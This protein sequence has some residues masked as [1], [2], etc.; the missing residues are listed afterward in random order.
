MRMNV[1]QGKRGRPKKKR[2]SDTI[3]NDMRA[4]GLGRRGCGRPGQV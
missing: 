2:R 1:E 4:A 3:E